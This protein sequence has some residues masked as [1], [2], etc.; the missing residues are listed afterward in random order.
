MGAADI[1]C[2]EGAVCAADDA[3][4]EVHDPLPPTLNRQRLARTTRQYWPCASNATA[5]FR[6]QT[7]DD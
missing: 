2:N 5:R 6:T 1:A 3:A 4:E 7:W